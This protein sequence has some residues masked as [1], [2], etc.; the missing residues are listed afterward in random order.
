L[1]NEVDEAISLPV[2]SVYGK[3][4]RQFVFVAN[5]RDVEPRQITLGSVS[6]EWAE[7][8]DGLSEG[9]RILLAFE[10]KHT[11]MIPDAP[12]KA[13]RRAGMPGQ[14]KPSGK[15]G[16]AMPKGKR[17]GPKGPQKARA[18]QPSTSKSAAPT[19]G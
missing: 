11:R 19:R 1:V 4:G 8:R 2:Q 14:G 6:T 13:S 5:D 12:R 7:V 10:E 17:G 18:D 3:G 9:E 15:P 16:G